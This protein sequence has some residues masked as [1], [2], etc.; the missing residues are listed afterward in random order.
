M[1]M[2]MM[3]SGEAGGVCLW[4]ISISLYMEFMELAWSYFGSIY[5]GGLNFQIWECTY[6]FQSLGDRII[7]SSY[8]KLS[9]LGT[10]YFK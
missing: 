9:K 4:Y 8:F 7:I 10:K 2:R 6:H 3:Y 1:T 5:V